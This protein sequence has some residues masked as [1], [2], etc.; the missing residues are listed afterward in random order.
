MEHWGYEAARSG[1]GNL[2]AA[3]TVVAVGIE[4]LLGRT[5]T[6]V[7]CNLVEDIDW[8]DRIERRSHGDPVLV[9]R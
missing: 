6:F 8:M 5:D 9:H 1:L 4:S 2:V 3:A 7:D